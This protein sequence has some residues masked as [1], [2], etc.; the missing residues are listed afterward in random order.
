MVLHLAT[1]DI[2]AADTQAYGRF[3]QTIRNHVAMLQGDPVNVAGA[4]EQPRP[5]NMYQMRQA[6]REDA[7]AGVFFVRLRAEGQDLV[8]FYIQDTSLY[9][10]GFTLP[11]QADF[12]HLSNAPAGVL[13]M[14]REE[15]FTPIDT[16]IMESYGDPNGLPRNTLGWANLTT[17]LQMLRER[18]D[19]RD[20]QRPAF[21]YLVEMICEA[22]RFRAIGRAL[23]G[24]WQRS[25]TISAAQREEFTRLETNWHTLSSMFDRYGN[26]PGQPVDRSPLTDLYPNAFVIAWALTILHRRPVAQQGTSRPGADA[27]RWE[28]AAEEPVPRQRLYPVLDAGGNLPNG[29][30]AYFLRPGTCMTYDIN[31][32]SVEFGPRSF[33]VFFPNLTGTDFALRVDTLVAVPG[34]STDVWMFSGRQY[35]RY[36]VGSMNVVSGPQEI[37]AGWPAL[38][39][40]SFVDYID[41][42]V[43]DPGDPAHGLF[44]F[45]DS[46]VVY[47][48]LDKNTIT[49]PN[50]IALHMP[51][52][53]NTDFAHGVSAAVKVPRSTDQMW[54]FRGDDY[55]RYNIQTHTVE[56]GPRRVHQGWAALGRT[57]FVDGVSAVLPC[58]GRATPTEAWLFH[59][60]LYLRI[61]LANNTV[62]KEAATV[63]EGWPGLDT[64]GFADR[65]DAALPCPKG[66]GAP[67]RAWFFHDD[68]YL[69]Y[70]L[71]TSTVEVG[72]RSI[73][74]GW[75]GLKGT[76][77]E[78]GVDAALTDPSDSNTVW[79]FRG[80]QYV[81]YH[82][83]EDRVIL[84]PVAI[85]KRWTGLSDPFTRHIDA[86][87]VAPGSHDAWLFSGDS[88]VRYNP[89]EDKIHVGPRRIIDGW[90]LGFPT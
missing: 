18:P 20:H 86:A 71:N 43:H 31:E 89:Q 52:L 82:L 2:D 3:V 41:A 60:D 87:C 62:A 46:E 37:A 23:A 55:L 47:Y 64:H 67:D 40:T 42:A 12:Y 30:G 85:A 90:N 77:F 4:N 25:G 51:G 19:L 8:D 79:M 49:G 5:V 70:N 1:L 11:G 48:H 44:L 24:L 54:L 10:W 27:T 50:P 26:A 69:R 81:H 38:R 28:A 53:A 17:A 34:S 36:A 73:A 33:P 68:Q 56:V 57:A 88:Y 39:T 9:G 16:G 6:H 84:G 75:T 13:A 65:V 35:V 78:Y 63:A 59:D 66:A 22:T 29:Y 21:G 80:D 15:R 76:G 7:A 72:P 14:A 45:R 58:T 32:D 83:K 61:N 74:D